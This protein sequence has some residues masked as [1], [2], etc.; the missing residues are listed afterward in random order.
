MYSN[1][2]ILGNSYKRKLRSVTFTLYCTVDAACKL[3]KL[4]KIGRFILLRNSFLLHHLGIVQNKSTNEKFKFKGL[5]F[6]TFNRDRHKLVTQKQRWYDSYVH[7]D[8][9]SKLELQRVPSRDSYSRP[10]PFIH[11]VRS[12]IFCSQSVPQ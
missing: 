12:C 9:S 5:K 6:S 10:P 11:A 3:Q 8:I 4:K 1:Q 7:Y 2:K